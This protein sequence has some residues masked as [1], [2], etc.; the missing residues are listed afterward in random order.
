AAQAQDYPNRSVKII[1][2]AAAGSVPDFLARTIGQRLSE[3]WR[4]PVVIDNILGAGGNIGT[5]R[6]AKAPADGYTLLL[7]TIAP[8]AVNQSLMGKLPYDP[9]KDLAPITQVANTANILAVHP[10]FPAKSL[11]D[12]I[13]M[14]KEQPGKLSYPSGGHG[15]TQHLSGELLNTMAGIKLVHIPYKSTG[16][17]TTDALGGQIQIIFHNAPVLLPHVRSG[18]LRGIAVTSAK[19]QPYAAELPTM[20]E[21]GLPGFEVSA[22]FGFMAP[23]GTP[24]AIIAKLHGEIVAIMALPDMRERFLAQAAEPVGNRPDEYAAFIQSEIVK[25][26]KVVKE[27]GLK[28]D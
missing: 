1:V 11:Q 15:T 24:P 22:F 20:S 21:A 10:S 25:W 9:V 19:R 16:Q 6:A 14:A 4:Q 3:N 18:A 28:V 17:M 26:A 5:D 12:I 8:I 23:A 2:P 27:A 7:N 13:R